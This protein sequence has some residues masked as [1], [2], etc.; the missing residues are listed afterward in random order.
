MKLRFTRAA[1]PP[2]GL[3]AGPGVWD[4]DAL[5]ALGGSLRYKRKHRTETAIMGDVVD[6]KGL[7]AHLENDL[8][9]IADCCRFAE[10]L[11]TEAQV[12]KKYRLPDDVWEK[13]G[14]D[15]KL[16]EKIEAEKIRRIRDGSSKRERAQMLVVRAP[17]VLAGI[18]GDP[19][20]NPRHRIDSAKA[21]DDFAAN[22]P[23]AAP[24]G[25]R[26]QITINLGTDL[27][28]KPVI[29]SYDKS[30]SINANDDNTSDTKFAPHAHKPWDDYGG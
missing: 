4:A 13:L 10:K 25:D 17:D 23:A 7:P 1:N 18:L 24:T 14:D 9:F 28:G 15:D 3:R 30:I 6:L 26:F 11:L 2:A 20:A 21:L 8:E 29:E 12:R 19:D 16:V 22:G 5:I 27:D